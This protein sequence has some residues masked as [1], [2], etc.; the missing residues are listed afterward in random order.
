MPKKPSTVNLEESVWN[1]IELF[2]KE[3][4]VNRNTAIEW[5]LL[6]RE[7]MI[8][9]SELNQSIERKITIE[10]PETFKNNNVK[11][12]EKTKETEQLLVNVLKN[13]NW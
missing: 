10:L 2:M 12:E 5:M 1:D 11:Q 4:N 7:M 13:I 9:N 6:E 3:N 8:K